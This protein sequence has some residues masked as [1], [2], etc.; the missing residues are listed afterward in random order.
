MFRYG[1]TIF[2]SA[3]LLFQVQ[4]LF[5]RFILPWF[6]G[7]PATWA[8]CL[9]C[10]QALL[11]AGYS[12]AHLS[13]SRLTPRQQRNVHVALL[14][15]GLMFLPIVPGEGWKPSG[16]ESPPLRILGVLAFTVGVPYL[17][18]SST[19]PLMQ[20]WLVREWP[21]VSPYR[22][23]ALS[24]LGSFLGLVSYP[25]VVEPNLTLRM[26]AYL[27]SSLFVGFAG[28]AAWC[29]VRAGGQSVV[30]LPEEKSPATEPVSPPGLFDRTLWLLLPMC[31]S[32]MLLATTNE[33]S[34]DVAAV[35]F[36]WVLPLS[37]Y[38]LSF[39]ITF[40]SPR[41]YWRP[42]WAGL[43]PLSVAGAY[44]ATKIGTNLALPFQVGLY[45]GALLACCMVLH[46]EL[47]RL[48]PHHDW[49]TSFFL[50]I[51]AGGALGAAMVTIVAPRLVNA[52]YEF[53]V[54]LML[55]CFLLALV[56]YRQVHREALASAAGAH[57]T[58]L[59]LLVISG[60]AVILDFGSTYF[61]TFNQYGQRTLSSRIRSAKWPSDNVREQLAGVV[62]ETWQISG[63]AL[64]AA[65]LPV[66]VRRRQGGPGPDWITITGAATVALVSGMVGAN[67]VAASEP[68][69]TLESSRDFFGVLR[70]SDST[71]ADPNLRTLTNGRITHGIQRLDDEG[72]HLPTTYYSEESGVGVAINTLRQQKRG[73]GGGL[74]IG[75]VGL[76]AG[77]LAAY[78]KEGDY[79]RFYE[80]NAD[81]VRL[82]QKHF[83][84][85]KY[86]PAHIDVTLGDAR[87]TMERERSG[88][89]PQSFDVVAV[90]AFSGD[91]VPLHLL[92]REAFATYFYHLAPDGVLAMHVS[93]HYLKLASLVRDLAGDSGRSAVEIQN[94]QDL[95]KTIYSSTWVLVTSNQAFLD[96]EAVRSHST[97]WGN[98]PDERPLVFTD[99]YANIFRILRRPGRSD[100]E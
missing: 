16:L 53:P 61:A 33:M 41:W 65:F 93:N 95:V 66:M 81:V 18:L 59:V 34:Q 3:F 9:L 63:F 68:S 1:V 98:H 74:R 55:S 58:L 70:V 42:I 24:N 96:D 43:M 64:M 38:L 89:T 82:N 80:I 90:D 49:L 76:G 86:T 37:L 15:V 69:D 45:C 79:I 88:Q 13:V 46:G 7:S 4:P 91:A 29:A 27:W 47:A 100:D 2:V 20:A 14:L 36:L 11:L 23:Y 48:K 51:S 94:G 62:D 25:F 99:D 10:F 21:G 26:Q 54:A 32:V 73:G 67:M 6:G 28:L 50:T 22:F 8:T 5:G 75:V 78:G 84:F 85:L 56:L 72:R 92:T 87:I 19:T 17:I 60:A 83:T 44:M 71:G 52:F 57:V 30:P 12:Y 40:D 77:T 35:P 97:R 39:T 31:G